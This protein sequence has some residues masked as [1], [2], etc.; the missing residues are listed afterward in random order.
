MKKKR[1]NVIL[2]IMSVLVILTFA[3]CG[4]L[5]EVLTEVFFTDVRGDVVNAM[6]DASST[7]YWKEDADTDLVGATISFYRRSSDGTYSTSA[8]STTTVSTTGSFGITDLLMGEYKIS[9]EKTG[10][11][12]V[13]RYVNISGEDMD[14]PPV[15]AYPSQGND[16]AVILLSWEDTGLD[17]DA[18]LTY[19]DGSGRDYIGYLD[20]Y[21]ETTNN[22][23]L[24]G[25]TANNF[26]DGNAAN[27]TCPITR[28]RDIQAG[29]SA[30]IPR[31]E[32]I[33][34]P[35][36]DSATYLGDINGVD[37]A[38]TD[39]LPETNG[40][41]GNQLK[42]YVNCYNSSELS[43]TGID[44]G[45]LTDEPFSNAQVDIMYTDIDGNTAHY[46]GASVPWNT[47]SNILEMA[48]INVDADF[49]FNI[50]V[51]AASIYDFID[52][53]NNVRTAK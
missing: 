42:L 25:I 35:W 9:G 46:G 6:A 26:Q 28:P 5:E 47:G 40:V 13:P 16:T 2:S 43:L 45:L 38:V 12:F 17:L 15:I 29:T 18:I 53:T 1:K 20:S 48:E 41:P 34:I 21:T 27:T 33:I 3:S 32:T 51:Y 31:V 52:D 10:W 39:I 30:T 49:G 37:P 14:L 7:E 50:N 24:Q 44:E 23:T 8:A 11:V 19:Y 36:S 4:F 22:L